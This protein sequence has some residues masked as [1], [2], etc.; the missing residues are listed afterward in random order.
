MEKQGLQSIMTLDTNCNYNEHNSS[1]LIIT[2]RGYD[3]LG[4]ENSHLLPEG[5]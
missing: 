5:G 1:K 4:G 3:Y 2:S